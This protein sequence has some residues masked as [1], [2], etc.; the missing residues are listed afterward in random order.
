MVSKVTPP[1]KNKNLVQFNYATQLPIVIPTNTRALHAGGAP[2]TDIYIAVGMYIH[3][4]INF[5][6]YAQSESN[7]MISYAIFSLRLHFFFFLKKKISSKNGF[8]VQRMH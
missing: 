3:T 5:S 4:Y 6:L 2:T 1:L 8:I 7:D